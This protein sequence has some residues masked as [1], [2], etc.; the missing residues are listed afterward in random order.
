MV[1]HAH[2]NPL[3]LQN[4]HGHIY[5]YMYPPAP[6]C[7]GPPGCEAYV[8]TTNLTTSIPFKVSNLTACNLTN[9]SKLQ[10]LQIPILKYSIL[11]LA[12]WCL[13]VVVAPGISRFTFPRPGPLD[14]GASQPD[15]RIQW[16]SNDLPIPTK[17]LKMMP[18]DL[19]RPPNWGP[20]RYL[21]PS[22]STKSQKHEI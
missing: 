5:I 17:T 10:V 9:L 12:S 3:S 7:Q 21:K 11:E 16:N 20:K 8:V 19:Q 22:K 6:A 4:R 1:P 18:G 2:P 14:S 13:V 15:H